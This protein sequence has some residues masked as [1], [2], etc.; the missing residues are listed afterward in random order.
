MG[1]G[2]GRAA[3]VGQFTNW[4]PETARGGRSAGGREWAFGFGVWRETQQPPLL[5]SARQ[6]VVAS[7]R[8]RPWLFLHAFVSSTGG[9]GNTT[10]KEREKTIQN[11]KKNPPKPSEI[12]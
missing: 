2:Q 6:Q 1:R 4:L 3:H 12:N 9:Q 5:H 10:L 8:G 11:G 7:V